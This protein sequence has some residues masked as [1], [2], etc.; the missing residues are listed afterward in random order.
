MIREY[1]IYIIPASFTIGIAIGI[2]EGTYSKK[3]N[4]AM[5]KAVYEFGDKKE[6]LTIE[7][8][9]DWYKSMGVLKG[10]K[11]TRLQLNNYLENIV[12]DKHEK[13]DL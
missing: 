3:Y 7:E 2:I 4:E 6:P 10:D 5:E 13:N 9:Q 1:M 11:P 12:S 8:E